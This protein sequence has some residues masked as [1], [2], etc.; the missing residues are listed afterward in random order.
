[1]TKRRVNV[2]AIGGMLLVAGMVGSI[3]QSD[4][5]GWWRGEAKYKGRYTNSWRVELRRW[6]KVSICGGS[7]GQPRLVWSR[8]PALWHEWLAEPFA[9]PGDFDSPVSPPL[10][11][12]DPEAIP[13]LVELLRAPE[14]NVRLI[15]A[16]A[17]ASFG[18]GTTEGFLPAVRAILPD[19]RA[20]LDDEDQERRSQAE[21]TLRAIERI[22]FWASLVPV[23]AGETSPPDW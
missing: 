12:G 21:Q 14:P 23:E 16:E 19:I 17:L 13:V 6:E 3:W 18:R 1:M 15:A 22:L 10:L 4:L 2:L 9:R 5:I 20:T 7:S 11:N 8:G